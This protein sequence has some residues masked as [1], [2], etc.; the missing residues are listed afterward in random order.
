MDSNN[1]SGIPEIEHV[2]IVRTD[3][4]KEYP[5]A[6]DAFGPGEE[7]PERL[8]CTVQLGR[9][10]QIYHAVRQL[11]IDADLDRDRLGTES[12]NPLG[13][14]IAPGQKV[15]ILC[16]F[17]QHRRLIQTPNHLLAK[18]V[19]A[20]VL[21]AV[22]D[23][24]LI[25]LGGCGEVIFGNAP[26]QSTDWGAVMKETGA[27][28]IE[29]FYRSQKLPVRAC[30]LRMMIRQRSA[31]GMN[32]DEIMRDANKD[33]IRVDLS[34]SSLLGNNPKASSGGA[35]HFRVMDYDPHRTERFQNA[36]EHVYLVHREIL[37]SD[38]IISLPKLKTHEKV[39]ITCGLKGFVGI[40]GH[41]DCLAHHRFG[42]PRVGGDEYPSDSIFRRLQSLFHDY[43]NSNSGKGFLRRLGMVVDR[44]VTRVLSR[45]GSIYG[46]SWYGNDTCWRMALDLARIAHYADSS[47]RMTNSFQRKHLCFI[48]GI[49]AGEGK[50]PLSPSPVTAGVLIFS[51]DVVL[52]DLLAC[53]LMGFDPLKLPL[54]REAFGTITNA[55]PKMQNAMDARVIV[56]G[57][58]MSIS[59][60]RPVLGRPFRH[61]PGW[62]HYLTSDGR[63][64]T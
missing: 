22:C 18:C 37:S 6:H 41:K 52:A 45:A 16:N 10:N 48:D 21:R 39:G 56:N 49:I 31:S 28:E 61:S 30:D 7:L 60:I 15:F 57:V 34:Q 44:N 47:G 8:P 62:D 40:V 23:Y 33:C 58:P 46:G 11:F 27:A 17:V 3:A 63:P 59:S 36:Q 14:W 54:I 26:L 24:V 13:R 5:R 53:L 4:P 25:A 1:L 2:C 64:I 35:P 29:T 42:G 43:V 12:W 32:Y 9:R 55:Y 51:E 20:S 50:G 38:V 19:H